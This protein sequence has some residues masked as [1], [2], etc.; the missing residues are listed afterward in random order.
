MG[1]WCWTHSRWFEIDIGVRDLQRLLLSGLGAPASVREVLDQDLLAFIIV[2][3][4]DDWGIELH[5]E[6]RSD[7]EYELPPPVGFREA[8][9]MSIL[10]D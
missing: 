9:F 1:W 3:F 10:S 4:V 5:W 7:D 2:D 6:D 8:A